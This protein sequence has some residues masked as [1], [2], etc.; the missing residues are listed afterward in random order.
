MFDNQMRQKTNLMNIT[1]WEGKNMYASL[2]L[3]FVRSMKT[4]VS[5]PRLHNLTW[6]GFLGAFLPI[7]SVGYVNG[8]K[9]AISFLSISQKD[10][11]F[12][13]HS[14]H[15]FPGGSH[16]LNSTFKNRLSSKSQI[17]IKRII[18]SPK[19]H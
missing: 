1:G 10:G 12:R 13:T 3:Y 18:N 5:E 9:I 6:K 16:R 7:P 15:R 4:L 8:N 11:I 14:C 17:K 2:S 19:W